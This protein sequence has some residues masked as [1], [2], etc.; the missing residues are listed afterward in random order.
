MDAVCDHYGGGGEH[1]RQHEGESAK[2][3]TL[4]VNMRE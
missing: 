1:E 2:P 4:T 3:N